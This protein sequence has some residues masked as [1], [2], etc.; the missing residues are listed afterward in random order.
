MARRGGMGERQPGM[1]R[2]ETGLGARAD[3]HENEN[4]RRK[5]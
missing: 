5:L 4:E 3:Q 2:H 1:Q